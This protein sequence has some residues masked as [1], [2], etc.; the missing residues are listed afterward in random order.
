MKFGK[1][2]RA[3]AGCSGL[4]RKQGQRSA[5]GFTSTPAGTWSLTSEVPPVSNCDES[6]CFVLCLFFFF[7]LVYYP[8]LPTF[9]FLLYSLSGSLIIAV[10]WLSS[11]ALGCC[12]AQALVPPVTG[13]RAEMW[14][15]SNIHSTNFVFIKD[16]VFATWF[17]WFIVNWGTLGSVYQPAANKFATVGQEFLIILL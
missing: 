6:L 12:Q 9:H 11:A 10:G 16:P 14:H 13:A 5:V 17:V 8:D 3:E 15:C 1:W 4:E 2:N 7:R